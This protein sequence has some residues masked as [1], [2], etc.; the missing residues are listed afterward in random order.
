M[1]NYASATLRA[2]SVY[3]SF[4]LTENAAYHLLRYVEVWRMIKTRARSVHV[5]MHVGV[6]FPKQPNVNSIFVPAQQH[7]WQV[8]DA[9]HATTR[10]PTKHNIG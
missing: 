4:R 8:R 5:T 6:V 1:S 3:V 7:L 2:A 9:R 10:Q